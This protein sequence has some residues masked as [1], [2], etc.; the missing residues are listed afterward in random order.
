VLCEVAGARREPDG[1]PIRIE[2]AGAREG[3][4][5]KHRESLGR[6]GYIHPSI[7]ARILEIVDSNRF[8]SRPFIEQRDGFALQPVLLGDIAGEL[9]QR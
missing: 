3:L 9:R 4:G 1:P 5:G 6:L 2:G 8:R 7:P